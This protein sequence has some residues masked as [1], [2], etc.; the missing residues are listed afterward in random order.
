M[1][2][3]TLTG[4]DLDAVVALA[5][6]LE[7]G[8]YRR[9]GEDTNAH[10]YDTRSRYAAHAQLLDEVAELVDVGATLI[11][12][13]L[14]AALGDF[15]RFV[16]A[17]LDAGHNLRNRVVLFGYAAARLRELLAILEELGA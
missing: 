11:P 15:E 4:D 2:T 7:A 3:A 14:E 17:E 6:A 10:A 12:V 1:T 8:R 16:A 9:L 13:R 5:L